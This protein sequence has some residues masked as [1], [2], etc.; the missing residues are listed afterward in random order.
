MLLGVNFHYIRSDFNFPFSG[1]H[2]IKPKQFKNQ[3]AALAEQGEFVSQED[4]VRAIKGDDVLPPKSIAITFDD[5]LKEQ[6]DLALPILASMGIP[7]TF[8]FNSINIESGVISPIHKSH[9]IRATNTAFHIIDRLKDLSQSLGLKEINLHQLSIKAKSA[10]PYDEEPD[11]CLKYYLNRELPPALSSEVLSSLWRDLVNKDE[12]LLAA[13][14][15]MSRD[16]IESLGR[17]G[18]LG[19]HGHEHLSMRQ[20]SKSSRESQ[21]ERSIDFLHE[22]KIDTYCKSFSFPYGSEDS[23]CSSLKPILTKYGISFSWTMERA[24]NTNLNNPYFLAR[25][26]CSDAPGGNHTNP[27]CNNIFEFLPESKWFN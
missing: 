6:Y 25:I 11:A 14:W 1:I 22:L 16:Q 2:G 18:M 3:L 4:I 19:S 24:V 10:Y 15:Y 12:A 20:Q 17:K 7:A 13:E 8:Y 23:C 9:Y 5:G 21:I 27:S 26:S